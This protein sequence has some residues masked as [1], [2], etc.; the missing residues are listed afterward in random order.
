M[1]GEDAH[2]GPLR[3]LDPYDALRDAAKRQ[4]SDEA[5]VRSSRSTAVDYQRSGRRQVF[6]DRLLAFASSEKLVSVSG[7]AFEV[8]YVERVDDVAR[9]RP[10]FFAGAELGPVGL[11]R[12]HRSTPRI[13]ESVTTA[14]WRGSPSTASSAIHSG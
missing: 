7:L 3:P 9:M 13:V 14:S 2:D 6:T 11:V 12:A 1:I 10:W 8:G 4:V 5:L